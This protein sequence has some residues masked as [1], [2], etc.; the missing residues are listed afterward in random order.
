MQGSGRIGVRLRM[1]ERVTPAAWHCASCRLPVAGGAWVEFAVADSGPG[2][3]P[4]LQER[5]FDPFFSTKAPGQGSGMGLA[6]VHG[7]VHDHGG[8]LQLRSMPGDGAEFAVWLPRVTTGAAGAV[9]GPPAVRASRDA[10]HARVLLVEDDPMVGD[11]LAERL[12]SWGLAVTLQRDP[13]AALAWLEDSAH[14]VDLL[15]TDQTMPQLTGLQ[16]AR[17]VR[18]RRPTLPVLLVSGNAE[19]FDASD[20]QACGIAGMLPKPVDATRLRTVLDEL[21]APLVR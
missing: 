13:L 15:L 16:L 5:I 2:I 6:M 10:L 7:I 12:A 4:A 1:H 3:E 21:L 14:A 11:F 18:E 20:L 19:A 9:A 17:R 8:H